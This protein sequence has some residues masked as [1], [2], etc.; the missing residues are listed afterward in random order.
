MTTFLRNEHSGETA[1]ANISEAAYQNFDRF[2]RASEY[3]RVL[4]PNNSAP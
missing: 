2:A 1:S 3:G 4:S